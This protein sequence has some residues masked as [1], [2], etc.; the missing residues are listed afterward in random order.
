MSV[1]G[2]GFCQNKFPPQNATY[3]CFFLHYYAFYHRCDL[4]S[5]A[6]YNPE[7]TVLQFINQNVRP[8]SYSLSYMSRSFPISFLLYILNF[9]F[10]YFL[11]PL[12]EYY[13]S[14]VTVLSLEYN[15]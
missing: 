6:T 14:E 5:R 4:Y 15:F 11:G 12:L 2:L 7:N 3:I 13:Y 1:L 8:F 9:T 10:A